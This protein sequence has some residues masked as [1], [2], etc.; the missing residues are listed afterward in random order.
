[1]E[2]NFIMIFYKKTCMAAKIAF[3]QPPIAKFQSPIL[4]SSANALPM[5]TLTN[6]VQMHLI[7]N[8]INLLCAIARY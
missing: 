2:K 6:A 8:T 7:I 5:L 3:T 4:Q 1:M